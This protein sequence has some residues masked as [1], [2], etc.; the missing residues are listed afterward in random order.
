MD[1]VFGHAGDYRRS[2]ACTSEDN[3]SD[4]DADNKPS[5]FWTLLQAGKLAE[6]SRSDTL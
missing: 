2:L 4:D 6:V 3:S 1:R 5:V